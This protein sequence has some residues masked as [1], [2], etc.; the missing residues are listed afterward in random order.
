MYLRTICVVLRQHS[1]QSPDPFEAYWNMANCRQHH[2]TISW[3][4]MERKKP[5][6]R[7]KELVCVRIKIESAL[8]IKFPTYV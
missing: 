5:S 2:S 4:L 8:R 6:K 3:L 7:N 1:D